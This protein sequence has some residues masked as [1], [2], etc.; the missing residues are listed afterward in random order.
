MLSPG[1]AWRGTQSPKAL[2]TAK[3][4]LSRTLELETW[5]RTGRLAYRGV[6]DLDVERG[7]T[8]IARRITAAHTVWE[9]VAR[10]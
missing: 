6:I 7:E 3:N 9:I 10:G 2:H 4:G 8:A 5:R 1:S